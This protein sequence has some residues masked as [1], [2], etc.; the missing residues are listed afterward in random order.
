MQ[1]FLQKV[2]KADNWAHV[3]INP[4]FSLEADC[5][6]CTENGFNRKNDGWNGIF[7]YIHTYNL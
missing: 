4:I 2:H 7:I 1:S 3:Y 5:I 6:S